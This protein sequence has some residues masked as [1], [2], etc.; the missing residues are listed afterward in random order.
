MWGPASDG[1]IFNFFPQFG[2][3]AQGKKTI[4]G[5]FAYSDDFNAYAATNVF[6]AN[7]TDH[8]AGFYDSSKALKTYVDKNG[9]FYPRTGSAT[10]GTAPVYFT[11]G[12]KLSTAVAGVVE[13]DGLHRVTKAGAVRYALG[14]VLQTFYTTA[15]NSTTVE[16]DL[17]TYTIPA[18]TIDTDGSSVEFFAGGTIASSANTKT[19]KAY[20]AGTQ[21]L[22]SGTGYAAAAYN[23]EIRFTVTRNSSSTCRVS[24]TLSLTTGGTVTT[25]V[26]NYSSSAAP[27]FTSTNIIKITGQGGASTEV[28]A[29]HGKVTYCPA[30]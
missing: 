6:I 26:V 18:N 16:T 14:G 13:Y 28:L 27:N 17:Y 8:I 29:Q 15:N 1:S 24:G 2:I 11:S 30:P 23:W 22:T 21:V 12:T 4:F 9:A 20:F 25:T 3:Q 10:A 19:I 5:P 7:S